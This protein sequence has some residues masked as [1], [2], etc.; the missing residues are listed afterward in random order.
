[1]SPNAGITLSTGN[2]IP[3]VTINSATGPLATVSNPG[4]LPSLLTSSLLGLPS[5][6]AVARGATEIP[7][8][9]STISGLNDFTRNPGGAAPRILMPPRTSLVFE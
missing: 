9:M 2:G 8:N 5:L 4:L 3:T 1:V 6:Q 7:K